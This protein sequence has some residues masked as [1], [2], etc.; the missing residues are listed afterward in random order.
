MSGVRERECR[1][2]LHQFSVRLGRPSRFCGTDSTTS[3]SSQRLYVCSGDTQIYDLHLMFHR[4]LQEHKISKKYK[5]VGS[6][7][8]LC[9]RPLVRRI[10]FRRWKLADAIGAPSGELLNSDCDSVG[11]DVDINVSVDELLP[12]EMVAATDRWLATTSAT[13]VSR[14]FQILRSD[15]RNLRPEDTGWG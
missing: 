14:G 13:V 8:Y 12:L 5:A 6:Q 2:T 15:L 11:I 10:P 9:L 1:R 4:C 7:T 3:W